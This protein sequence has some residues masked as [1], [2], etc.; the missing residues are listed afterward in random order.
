MGLRVYFCAVV[1]TYIYLGETKRI[2]WQMMKDEASS[3]LHP[4]NAIVIVVDAYFGNK[5]CKSCFYD[6]SFF[7]IG[8][9]SMY[10]VGDEG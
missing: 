2:F 6:G 10:L 8:K 9:S 7:V 3:Y 1:E 5:A 4:P